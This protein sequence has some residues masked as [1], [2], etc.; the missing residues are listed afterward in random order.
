VGGAADAA[1]KCSPPPCAG[2]M[3]C[4]LCVLL[5]VLLLRGGWA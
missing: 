1:G 4:Q 3:A 2:A 5:L